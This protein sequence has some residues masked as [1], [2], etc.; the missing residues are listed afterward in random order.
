MA[1]PVAENFDLVLRTVGTTS[2][3]QVELCA[4]CHSRRT[5][6]GDYDHTRPDLLDSIIPRE[7]ADGLYHADG[8]ILDEVLES[9]QDEDE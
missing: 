2:R 8:Q 4:P 6:L 3:Q 5:E 1:R 7:L 9:K